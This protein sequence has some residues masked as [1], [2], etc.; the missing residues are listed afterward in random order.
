MRVRKTLEFYEDS[1]GEEE[2]DPEADA[3]YE[4][5]KRDVVPGDDEGDDPTLTEEQLDAHDAQW[6]EE[7]EYFEEDGNPD[8][9]VD[10]YEACTWVEARRVGGRDMC[11]QLAS[12]CT[13][14]KVAHSACG[15]WL[16][17]TCGSIRQWIET[18]EK[19]RRALRLPIARRP[20]ASPR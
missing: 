10:D 19:V 14:C 15:A 1:E 18:D 7:D 5:F 13:V 11:R 4:Q 20:R 8:M 6:D 9:A 12:L 17:E 3:L 16:V 2:R